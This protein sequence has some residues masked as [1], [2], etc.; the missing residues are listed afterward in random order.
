MFNKYLYINIATNYFYN[1]YFKMIVTTI[2]FSFVYFN[3][4]MVNT[5]RLRVFLN[6]KL[7]NLRNYNRNVQ[8]RLRCKIHSI[9][10]PLYIHNI[11]LQSELLEDKGSA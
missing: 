2:S 6:L 9:T 8:A 7:V 10:K 1:L 3:D 5:G 11:T 4:L